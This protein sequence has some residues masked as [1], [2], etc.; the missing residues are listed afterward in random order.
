MQME[1]ALKAQDLEQQYEKAQVAAFQLW[2]HEQD[3]DEKAPENAERYIALM[4]QEQ[5]WRIAAEQGLPL[6]E[7]QLDII[8]GEP[9][10]LLDPKAQFERVKRVDAYFDAVD[11]RERDQ[12]IQ[13]SVLGAETTNVFE[14]ISTPETELLTLLK[15]NQPAPRPQITK[16][17]VDQRVQ[18]QRLVRVGEMRQAVLAPDPADWRNGLTSNGKPTDVDT[19]TGARE[20]LAREQAEERARSMR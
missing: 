7:A 3:L 11:K 8:E 5:S 15:A 1:A 12:Q 9:V 16:A 14:G 2:A 10:Y 18:G 6:D 20:R 19:V 17:E 13:Q 4:E